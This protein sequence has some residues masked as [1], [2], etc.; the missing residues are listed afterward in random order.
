MDAEFWRRK[1]ESGS[2]GFHRADPNPM[3]VRHFAALGLAPGAR[4]F[5]PLCGK[6][7]DVGWLL[8]RDCAVAGAELSALAVAELFEEL[9]LAPRV[10]REG[11]LE[12]WEAE[13]LVVHVGDIFDLGRAALGAVDATWDRAALVALP[14][15]TR[16]R[17]AAHLVAATAAAP[18]LLASY[19]Y[20][21][22]ARTGPPF[23]VPEAEIRALYA[24]AYRVVS[25]ERRL[26]DDAIGAAGVTESVWLM[27]PRGA[28]VTSR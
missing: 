14:E 11:P 9:G 28:P 10:T 8:A 20:D 24:G 12:R 5:L 6:T 2:I 15:P 17:Y 13:R 7:R 16:R 21:P 4:V 1:W 27:T 18:Q 23:P 19:E 25:L 26:A 3:L 22:D